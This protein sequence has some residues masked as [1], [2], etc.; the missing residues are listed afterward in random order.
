MSHRV[1]RRNRLQKWIEEMIETRL[2]REIKR[3]PFGIG[4]RFDPRKWLGEMCWF[5]LFMM[6]VEWGPKLAVMA[7][8]FVVLRTRDLLTLRWPAK[9]H[10]AEAATD[11]ILVAC[12]AIILQAY[13]SIKA[14]QWAAS[15]AFA[16]LQGLGLSILGVAAFRTTFHL[17]IEDP[18]RLPQARLV[19]AAARISFMWMMAVVA[20]GFANA[21][22]VPGTRTRDFI[23]GI[24][25]GKT[26]AIM[27]GMNG[28]LRRLFGSIWYWFRTLPARLRSKEWNTD[29]ELKTKMND[30]PKRPD[31][32]L[33]EWSQVMFVFYMSI[34][35]FIAV[36][37]WWHGTDGNINWLQV[38]PDMIGLIPLM[39]LFRFITL[40]NEA[41]QKRVEQSLGSE[42]KAVES[43]KVS[44]D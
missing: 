1:V 38:W 18:K 4:T 24:V 7:V 12:A 42:S 43:Q 36:W 11:A 20:T 29:E 23:L 17:L 21:H 40:F 2:N 32:W 9:E 5:V 39:A 10:R 37:R 14:P 26:L 25:T 13:F 8:A 44:A 3:G 28:Y 33:A 15:N 22:A 30:L 27:C 19:G 31:N 35:F 16:L 6:A 41:V 34:T